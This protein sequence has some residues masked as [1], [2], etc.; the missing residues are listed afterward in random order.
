[1]NC[2]L[3]ERWL[4]DGRPE[5]ERA[6]AEAHAARCA[7]CAEALRV[8]LELETLLAA[9]PA[10]AP[11]ALTEHVMA[12]IASAEATR[13]RLPAAESP[14]LAWWIEAAAEPA[15]VLAAALAALVLWQ[16]EALVAIGVALASRTVDWWSRLAALAEKNLVPRVGSRDMVFV[17]SGLL[18]HPGLSSVL[19]LLG[20]AAA[21]WAAWALYHWSERHVLAA[22]ARPRP[23]GRVPA[24]PSR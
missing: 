4:D 15:T 21:L 20:L 13:A 7:S 10:A 12:R 14:V 6:A 2:E 3:F 1:M 19:E 5:A 8:A 24:L 22:P 11:P 17:P 18:A 16:R 23:R 9:P